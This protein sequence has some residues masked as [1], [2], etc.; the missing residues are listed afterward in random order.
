[1][2]TETVRFETDIGAFN[3]DSE[4]TWLLTAAEVFLYGFYVILFGFYMRILRT[5]RGFRSHPF[6]HSATTILF[7]LST[8]HL[9]LLLPVAVLQ[10]KFG[11]GWFWTIIYSIDTFIRDRSLP[12][13]EPLVRAAFGLYVT[14]S[15]VAD[16][17][18]VFRCYA[19]WGFRLMIVAVPALCTLGVAVFGYW[20]VIQP[21]R[22][23]AFHR[24][25][26]HPDFLGSTDHNAEQDMMITSFTIP[27]LISLV[28][29][30]ML[31]ILSAG[32]I[33]W[34][35]CRARKMMGYKTGR[36]YT[37]CALILESGAFYVVG[38][39]LLAILSIFYYADDLVM[40]APITAQ[41]AGIAPTIIAVRVGLNKSIES[42]D[43]FAIAV[44]RPRRPLPSMNFNASTTGPIQQPAVIYLRPESIT[45]T[46]KLETVKCIQLSRH[47]LD[48]LALEVFEPGDWVAS[49][50][51]FH[52]P[53]FIRITTSEG[54]GAS[55]CTAALCTG[56]VLS[57]AAYYKSSMYGSLEVKM[58]SN[59][60]AGPTGPPPE[61]VIRTI[62]ATSFM[63]SAEMFLYGAS[64]VLFGFY[65][66]IL[67]KP[68]EF[69][70]NRLLHSATITLFPL[71]T[72]HLALLL[73][74]TAVE[75][76]SFVYYM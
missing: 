66:T 16:S 49:E 25:G 59:P 26:P 58:S 57:Q 21:D 63:T 20:Q 76:S 41:L 45:E 43:S 48:D 1:M 13:Q 52:L 14:S 62:Q 39:V 3:T 67:R 75:T 53:V 27:I 17:I 9:A 15:V 22:I 70:K 5:S 37:V 11:N 4:R 73:S 47:H 33:W 44:Q 35:G 6:L 65:V 72:I 40:C 50:F 28:T 19:I 51:N 55:M 71:S 36:Y 32:R 12:P 56:M 42:V 68:G 31:M 61:D 24:V 10:N 64:V 46:Q 2:F 38:A 8:A 60:D 69:Q 23:A 29:N 30:L 74:I 34:L 54:C 7:L 18:F